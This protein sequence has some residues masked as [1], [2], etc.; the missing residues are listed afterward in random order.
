MFTLDQIKQAHAQMNSGADFPKFINDIKNIGVI[1]YETFVTDGRTDYFGLDG[2]NVSSDAK[3]DAIVI[4]EETNATQFHLDLK[5]HQKG[6]T[7][8]STFC[9]DCAKSGIVKWGILMDKMTCTY[10][11]KAGNEILVE[12]IPTV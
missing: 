3:Y 10:Y 5:A 2:F 11:N 9:S 6:Q 8:Y 7:N 12:T 1:G 4:A